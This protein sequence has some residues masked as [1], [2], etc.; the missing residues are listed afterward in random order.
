MN[1][2]RYLSALLIAG[3]AMAALP[4]ATLADGVSNDPRN[5]LLFDNVVPASG[6]DYAQKKMNAFAKAYN[7]VSG[8]LADK[9]PKEGETFA[10]LPDIMYK[11][12]PQLAEFEQASIDMDKMPE[13]LPW[14]SSQEQKSAL[15][16]G[17]LVDSMHKSLA[18][19]FNFL[20]RGLGRD[21]SARVAM[22]AY[23]RL[24]YWHKEKGDAYRKKLIA[25]SKLM[26]DYIRYKSQGRMVDGHFECSSSAMKGM[27]SAVKKL[28]NYFD[29]NVDKKTL[30]GMRDG[31]FLYDLDKHSMGYA[32]NIKKSLSLVKA[33][34]GLAE[35]DFKNFWAKAAPVQKLDKNALFYPMSALPNVVSK[36]ES[37]VMYA[38]DRVLAGMQELADGASPEGKLLSQQFLEKETRFPVSSDGS[39]IR[40]IRMSCAQ[41]L[42]NTVDKKGREIKHSTH[43]GKFFLDF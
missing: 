1:A 37:R 30:R 4:G 5:V 3:C 34:R 13:G 7:E 41:N 42:L 33:A 2:M 29:Y 11:C 36:L 19:L 15:A 32:Q 43:G 35:V 16:Q 9:L 20:I 31:I 8:C 28:A 6:R 21:N 38:L 27:Q 25:M 26:D 22:F 18:R 14:H 23:D 39:F 12:E 24:L 40:S 10:F 17:A